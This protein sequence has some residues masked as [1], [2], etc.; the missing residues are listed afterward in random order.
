MEAWV[1]VSAATFGDE[2]ILSKPWF[3]AA[4]I[5]KSRLNELRM[6]AK[7]APRTGGP[8]SSPTRKPRWRPGGVLERKSIV[9]GKVKPVVLPCATSATPLAPQL[10]PRERPSVLVVS[11]IRASIM[12]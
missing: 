1:F 12:T 4:V 11:T 5:A 10:M 2:M 6:L 7:D 3:S 9:L 8:A